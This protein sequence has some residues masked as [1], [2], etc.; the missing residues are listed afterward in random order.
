[1]SA[2]SA[3]GW[4]VS[5]RSTGV[6]ATALAC[7]A[8]VFA[9]GRARAQQKAPEPVTCANCHLGV[10]NAYAHAPMRHALEPENAN[11][12]LMTHP[13]LSAQQ[14]GYAYTVQTKDGK[15]TYTV[16]GASGSL[17]LP[18]RWILGQQSQTWVLEKDGRFYE[19]MVS[20]FAKDQ[21]LAT[22]PGDDAIAPHTLTEAMGRELSIWEVRNCF[23]CHA[24]G[25]NPE[26]EPAPEKL[27]GGLDCERCHAGAAQ[28]MA[29]AQQV[30][31]KSIPK[32]L[33]KMNAGETSDFC[34]QCHRTWDKVVREGWHGPATVRFQPYRLANSRCF[35]SSDKRIACIACHD[36]HQQVNRNEAYYDGKCRACHAGGATAVARPVSAARPAAQATP[37]GKT[38]P[39]AKKNCVHCHMPKVELAGGHAVFTDHQIRVVRAGEAYPN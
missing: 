2:W 14:N 32:S 3:L 6:C 13:S 16:A 7:L 36:P 39:V 4:L 21:R 35:D 8:V 25:F 5:L 28:H 30:N 37:T 27:T 12:A 1:M 22:T 29:D 31:F 19:S 38:C 18:I 34:G 24:T 20:Y 15:S 23:T 17:T 26:E 9:C 11:P 10:V 33:K